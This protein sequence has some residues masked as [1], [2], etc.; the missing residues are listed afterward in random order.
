MVDA[1]HN[2]YTFKAV[3]TLQNCE[4][5]TYHINISEIDNCTY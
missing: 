4:I 2:L 5:I 1:L 3:C